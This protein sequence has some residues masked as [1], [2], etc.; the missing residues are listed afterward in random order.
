MNINDA[1]DMPIV[2]G[3]PGQ[4]MTTNGAGVVSFQTIGGNHNTLDMAYD[5]GGAGAGR[6][7]DAVDGTV[8]IN[9]ED[10]LL[11]TGTYLSGLQIG[12]PGGI[13]QGAGAR[14]FFNP[15][16]AAFRSGRVSGTQ[17]DNANVGAYSSAMGYN[18]CLLYTSPSPR[19]KRQS[20]MP[21]SA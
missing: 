8:A 9:G 15:Y 2:D 14:M 7:I 19:D 5:E 12:A 21:S 11:V 18:T 20:R 10:G 16:K 1:Y 4:V 17:W 3:A 13:P 6:S